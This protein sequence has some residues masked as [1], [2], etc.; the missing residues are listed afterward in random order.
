V[1]DTAFDAEPD[2]H[3]VVKLSASMSDFRMDY[4][5]FFEEKWAST[6]ESITKIDVSKIDLINTIF[7]KIIMVFLKNQNILMS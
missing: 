7:F 2:Q 3:H 5:P 6:G 4:S 1:S